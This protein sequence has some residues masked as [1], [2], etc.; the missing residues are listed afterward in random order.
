M[1]PHSRHYAILDVRYRLAEG[2]GAIAERIF[3]EDVVPIINK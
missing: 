2:L 1:T 3:P